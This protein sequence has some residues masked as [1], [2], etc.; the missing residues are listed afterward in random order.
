MTYF[1]FT[2]MWIKDHGQ[3]HK[4]KTS[5][6]NGKASSQGKYSHVKYESP[7]SYCYGIC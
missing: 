5:S 6:M 7:T 2:E 3:G 4:V 1:K